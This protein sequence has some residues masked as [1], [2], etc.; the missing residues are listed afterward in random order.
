MKE[1]LST[2]GQEQQH[3]CEKHCCQ[4]SLGRTKIFLHHHSG[5]VCLTQ[6]ALG[7]RRAARA[8]AVADTMPLV[9]LWEIWVGAGF[10]QRDVFICWQCSWLELQSQLGLPEGCLA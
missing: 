9:Q 5:P 1:S 6:A 2:G 10:C 4:C 8:A 3:I 7:S